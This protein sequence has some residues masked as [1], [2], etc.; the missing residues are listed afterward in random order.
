MEKPIDGEGIA[1]AKSAEDVAFVA[2]LVLDGRANVPPINA[3]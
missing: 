3:V 2:T 1:D